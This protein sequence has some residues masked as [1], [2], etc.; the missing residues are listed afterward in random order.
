VCTSKCHTICK[1]YSRNGQKAIEHCLNVII[2]FS[3]K[4]YNLHIDRFKAIL[5]CFG[6]CFVNLSHQLFGAEI[7]IIDLLDHMILYSINIDR[8]FRDLLELANVKLTYNSDGTARIDEEYIKTFREIF[9]TVNSTKLID[10]V[11]ECG[12]DVNACINTKCDCINNRYIYLKGRKFLNPHRITDTCMKKINKVISDYM[13]F[14]EA[15]DDNNREVVKKLAHTV[16][17][18][19]HLIHRGA[20]LTF[21]DICLMDDLHKPYNKNKILLLHNFKDK[22]YLDNIMPYFMNGNSPILEYTD[23]YTV[24]DK[25]LSITKGNVIRTHRIELFGVLKSLYGIE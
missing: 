15:Y 6:E 25:I 12:M 19:D 18:V 13:D 2:E 1:L 20:K 8:D 5:I 22:G 3:E 14:V 23:A 4:S 16:N 11:L 21:H 10:I 17:L 24:N 9:S 7:T